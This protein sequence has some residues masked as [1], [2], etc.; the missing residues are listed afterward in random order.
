MH[1]PLVS[2]AIRYVRDPAAAE[3]VVQTTW[4]GFC[5][6]L[7]RFQGRCSIKTWL[8]RI[9]F[10]NAQTRVNR[11]Q[12]T[13]PFSSLV[14]E[15]TDGDQCPVEP[16]WFR[17]TTDPVA[18]G[19]WAQ[20]PPSWTRTPE[21]LLSDKET[22]ESVRRA[23]DDLPSAQATVMQLR[24]VEGLSSREV[25]NALGIRETNQRVLLHRA[26]TRVRKILSNR[27]GSDI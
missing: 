2:A 19:H 15:E 3:D 18:P 12:R 5:R 14:R 24:D 23:M 8:F 10:N 26:R 21:Q 16:S 6:S 9:L 22:L 11:D 13:V 4:M 17:D 7:D 20:E 25:C 27:Y 1:Q